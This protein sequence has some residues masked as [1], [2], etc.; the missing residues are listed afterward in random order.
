MLGIV[1]AAGRGSRIQP[2]GFSKELLP[3]GSRVEGLVERPCAVSEY[4]VQRMIGGGAD[5]ICF[6]IGPGKS[7][8]LEYYAGGYGE[9][10][11]VF[12]VQPTPAGLCDAIF[13]AAPLVRDDEPVLIGLPDTVWYPADGFCA[14]PDDRLAFLLFPV[15]H[16]EFFD[17][18]VV[19]GND[20]VR[21]IQVK[22]VSPDEIPVSLEPPS[23]GGSARVGKPL[24]CA[25]GEWENTPGADYRVTWYRSNDVGP[26][27]PRYRAASQ[28]DLG[29]FTTPAEPEFGTDN[30]TWVDSLRSRATTRICM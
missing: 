6:V 7:D 20:R 15:D 14:L 18:V 5:K 3:V 9:T 19:D 17:A 4:L 13:R 12:V 21:E 22:Q 11:A 25:R 24:T 16:P 30:L 26:D 8:I 2:L 29:N 27:H 28:F 10:S 1:P 23:V